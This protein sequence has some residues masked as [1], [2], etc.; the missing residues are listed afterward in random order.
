MLVGQRESS[1]WDNLMENHQSW[2]ATTIMAWVIGALFNLV[3]NKK[4]RKFGPLT[5]E[6]ISTREK[7]WVKRAQ[8][9]VVNTTE[10]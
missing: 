2:R 3:S 6:K 8:S 4:Q 7:F 9:D 10:I 5:A 1:I